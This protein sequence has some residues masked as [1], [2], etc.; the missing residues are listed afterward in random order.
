MCYGLVMKMCKELLAS[1]RYAVKRV[2]T[3]IRILLYDPGPHAFSF[4]F[5]GLY[6]Y[7]RV[8]GTVKEYEE[9][10]TDHYLVGKN[11]TN[12]YSYNVA[13]SVPY[14]RNLT[15]KS[16]RALVFRYYISAPKYF[17]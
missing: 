3:H 12:T 2:H 5:A 10:N 7:A 11:D 9:C 16:C 1:V 6:V 4:Y 14:H 15:K 17:I 8:Q 13:I